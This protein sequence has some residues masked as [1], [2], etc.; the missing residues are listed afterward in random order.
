MSAKRSS[1]SGAQHIE[2]YT[3]PSFEQESS[4]PPQAT[5]AVVAAATVTG[6]GTGTGNGNATATASAPAGGSHIH[7]QSSNSNA[8]D[9]S[10]THRKGHR[11]QESMYQM[12]GLYSET[13]SG[14]DSSIDAALGDPQDPQSRSSLPPT[15]A[16][17]AA[18][19]AA[20]VDSV[21]VKCHSRQASAGKCPADEEEDYD[22][23]QFR[24]GDCGI[25]NCRP[26]SIQRFARIKIFVLLLSLLVM[27]QQALSSGYINSVITTIE[28]RFEIPSSYSGLIASSYEIGNVITVIFV[29]YLGSRRHIPVWIGIGAVIMGIGSLVFMVPHFTGEP[30]PGI[31]ILNKTSDNICRSALVRDQDMDLGRLSSGLSNQPLAPH[32]LREDNCL[33]GKASTTGPVL[34]FVLAQL[35]LG[36]GGSPL[37]T[38]GTTYV[39]DHVRTESSSM[40]IGCMYS[41]GAFGPVVGFLLGA[42]LLSFH[43][44]SLS[45]A[46]ISIT[47][48]DRRWVGLWWG[49]FLLCGVILLVVAVPF[50]SFPKVLAREKKK[51]RKSS[52]VQ[53]VL[54]N[55]SVVAGGGGSVG[56]VG[57]A[58]VATDEL[59]KVVKKVEIVAV[60]SKEE[61]QQLPPKVDT[62]YG[63][64]IK[65]IPKS[66]LRL[67]KN[68]VYIVTCLGAC[69]ELMIVSGFVVFL[70][71]YLETQFSLGKS[72][73][74]I[75]T[76]SIAVPGACI[77]IFLGG[78]ILKRFQL[79]PKGAVQFVLI[80]NVI[81]LACYAMLFFLGCD[82]LKMAGTTIP[83]Y[84]SNK[85]GSTLEQPFQVN[86]TAACN[87]G[88]ECLTSEVEPVCGNNGLTY[89]SPCH[90]GCTAFSSSSNYTNCACVHANI[91]SSIYRGAG[92]SQA[93]A[94][95]AREDFA[96]VTV[97]PV[98]TA[99]PCATPCRTIYPFLILLFFMTFLVAST[100]MPLL[101]IVLRSV[102]EEERSFALG[103]QFVIF[104][105]FGY[106]PAPILFGN[107]IDSTC[108]LWKS[109]CGEKGGRC[110]IYD[111]EKFRYKYVGLCASVKLVA[112]FIFI[113]DWWL[114]RRRR[115]LE[116]TKPL[117]ASDPI[118]GSIISLDK[119]FEEKL[120]GAEPAAGFVGGAG[121]L[122][123]PTDI[124]RHSRN[125]SRTMQMDYCYDKCGHVVPPTNTCN[126]PQTKSKKHFRSAS[127]DVKMIKSFARDHNS[128]SGPADAAGQEAGAGSS[129]KYKNLKKFQAHTRNHSTDLHDNSQPI[130]YIQNQLRPQDCAEEEDDDELT[131]GCGH[132]VKK[133]SRNHSYDQIYM[134]NN[135][136]FDADFLRHSHP[137]HNPKKNVNVLKNVVAETC[138]KLKNSNEMEAG[139]GGSGSRGHSRNNSKD[140]NTKSA[141]GAA[142]SSSGQPAA[143][144]PT[145]STGL[146]VLRHRRTNSKDLNY[147]MLAEVTPPS[148]AAPAANVNRGGGAAS[149]QQQQHHSRNTSHHKIQID[150]DRNEL[151]NDNYEEEDR[152][153]SLR[154]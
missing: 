68:P 64:D 125:D 36:C 103:M 96:E 150:D 136:R 78:C 114:V 43:M 16:P 148:A 1:G 122:I 127:C 120:S 139:G 102:S 59:G 20:S 8:S 2:Q 70:P 131:T 33:E 152:S 60:T 15:S 79:K 137:H 132:F 115:Q 45:S 105:L 154:L 95:S 5:G 54:P 35:L 81:C 143:E 4:D 145:A 28:K 91:S 113:V 76:G 31:A 57:A 119:L 100:Q 123:I 67:V 65:D 129:S 44:D 126:Q 3:N 23:E 142:P 75:F 22:E 97:V 61:Q 13:N 134:P 117:N 53:P 138:G 83:Y 37:F 34:L 9:A 38:L 118:I 108:L 107:L 101:M 50:F 11:R 88:C 51:I 7:I 94:L 151:I 27:M 146:S 121:E 17:A 153:S 46:T 106:I 85:G 144:Q 14:D 98:A 40:Y 116:K 140:L 19:A 39:D 141:S 42:Y 30:N 93:Q 104:R 135:I 58:V 128:S 32:T 74:N 55:N 56:G 66:M 6:T 147:T 25:L 80:T 49:G 21:M 92:G 149:H 124:L 24:S 99:G 12:T 73:A 63:K 112:L 89:F 47:P 26:N 69:M 90:A 130:R 71:K 82:N 133:H 18:A 48:G 87:F 72:Q 110:L 10:T 29:S 41:M 77:G 86:L 109:S 52:V 111:I 62:G 84:T